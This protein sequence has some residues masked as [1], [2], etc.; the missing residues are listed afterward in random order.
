MLVDQKVSFLRKLA[1]RITRSKDRFWLLLWVD[2]ACAESCFVWSVLS[3]IIGVGLRHC[4]STISSGSSVE[5]FINLWDP[6]GVESK[7]ELINMNKE[8]DIE[9]TQ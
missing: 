1:R 9:L 2:I 6:L 8:I 4:F 7:E 5:G 3:V